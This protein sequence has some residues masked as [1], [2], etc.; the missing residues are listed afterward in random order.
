MAEEPQKQIDEAEDPPKYTYNP[1]SQEY[2]ILTHHISLA[3]LKKCTTRKTCYAPVGDLCYA[4]C[5]D[6][7]LSVYRL[8]FESL[9]KIDKPNI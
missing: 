8:G 1:S 3:C 2:D 5:Y 4:K 7:M 6:M 9:G